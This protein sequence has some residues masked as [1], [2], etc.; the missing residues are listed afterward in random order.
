MVGALMVWPA[1]L[2]TAATSHGP[3]ATPDSVNYL[4]GAESFARSGD[5][6]MVNG[7]PMTLFPPGLPVILGSLLSLGVDVPTAAVVLNVFA[8]AA[9][10]ALSYALARALGLPR[11]A[12]LACTAVV[13]V[14]KAT[15]FVHAYLFSEPLFSALVLVT[16]LL[17]V[18]GCRAGGFSWPRLVLVGVAT[19]A[20]ISLRYLG[21]LLIPVVVATVF[22]VLLPRVG[23]LRAGAR[24]GVAGVVSSIGLVAVVTR[25]LSLGSGPLGPR[26]AG[27]VS[28][29]DVLA[30]AMTALGDYVLAG[31]LA[32][33]APVV[34]SAVAAALVASVVVAL[35]RRDPRALTLA[36]FAGLWWVVLAW[37]E[38]TTVIDPIGARLLAP[39]LTPMV[40]LIGYGAHELVRAPAGR[41]RRAAVRRPVVVV[42]GVALAAVLSLPVAGSV[43]Y[44][45]N[46]SRWGIGF[47]GVALQRSPLFAAIAG[48]P[49]DAGIAMGYPERL[50]WV[51]GRTAAGTVPRDD[52]WFPPARQKRDLAILRDKID[53]GVVTHVAFYERDATT[54]KPADLVAFGLRLE[55][56]ENFEDGALYEA[57]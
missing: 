33:L 56:L 8:V 30:Q 51:S 22:G 2:V 34:G 53:S 13:A 40:V 29:L 54:L 47:S 21:L 10:V 7:N 31:R 19:S 25:N 16:L 1:G 45:R 11:L 9:M 37:S 38:L 43:E 42:A 41:S 57:G 28:P 4:A 44:A 39:A 26:T 12:S 17:V 32:H 24:A 18:N 20:A 49:P 3:G 6:L 15:L 50:Y 14:S 52:H 5:V 23:W 55:L 48:L 46:T 27:V 36:G 35:V